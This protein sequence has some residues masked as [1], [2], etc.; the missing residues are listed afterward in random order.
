MLR[1]SLPSGE[2]AVLTPCASIHMAFM[3]FA[4]DVLFVDRS[5]TIVK[6]V[7]DL[8]PYRATLG[9]RKAHSAIELPAGTLL[10]ANVSV[11]DTVEFDPPLG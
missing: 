4:I 1:G 3:R 6:I 7:R 11:G 5:N 8:R 10:A 9:G 2:G